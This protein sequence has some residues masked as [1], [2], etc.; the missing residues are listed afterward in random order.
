MSVIVG[1]FQGKKLDAREKIVIEVSVN[2]ALSR[3]LINLDLDEISEGA[4][5]NKTK[6]STVFV[7]LEMADLVFHPCQRRYFLS[8]NLV[9][10]MHSQRAIDQELYEKWRREIKLEEVFNKFK[11]SRRAF[12]WRRMG[13]SIDNKD[14]IVAKAIIEKNLYFFGREGA[15]EKLGF[16]TGVMG[17]A[18]FTLTDAGLFVISTKDRYSWSKELI[19]ELLNSGLLDAESGNKA[20][21]RLKLET[22]LSQLKYINQKRDSKS[23]INSDREMIIH[24][25]GE[26][27]MV[28]SREDII[29]VLIS[30]G[31]MSRED[32]VNRSQNSIAYLVD[33]EALWRSAKDRYLFH[34]TL[35]NQLRK[36]ELISEEFYNEWF[37]YF[38]REK[39]YEELE[40]KL[41]VILEKE[42]RIIL[43][44]LVGR[45]LEEFTFND[46]EDRLPYSSDAAIK[47]LQF[48]TKVGLF[49][50]KEEVYCLK[51][52]ESQF[53]KI[54]SDIGNAR[55]KKE[56]LENILLKILASKE[57]PMDAYSCLR[58]T[59]RGIEERFV[60][61]L[62]QHFIDDRLYT[63][64]GEAVNEKINSWVEDWL[65]IQGWTKEA[66]IECIGKGLFAKKYRESRL[67]TGNLV[68][69]D[70]EASEYVK[71]CE[72]I[73]GLAKGLER[74]KRDE[75]IQNEN[76]VKNQTKTESR[77]RKILMEALRTLHTKMINAQNEG[78]EK[79]V[80]HFAEMII[81]KE[82]QAG[83]TIFTEEA[84]SY[85]QLIK[86]NKP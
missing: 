73:L 10:K 54:V 61:M 42:H 81:F 17:Q 12:P 49:F 59:R 58:L 63:F 25:L 32:A 5:L 72:T 8:A 82:S 83:V 67:K 15:I 45:G 86:K 60:K 41:S 26:K 62:A 34:Q 16:G 6:L 21:R 79:M 43:D 50:K 24:L 4:N 46:I 57:N 39:S 77:D 22:A 76:Q 71:R 7:G 33:A 84:E 19:T 1:L 23:L 14:R 74:V 53:F 52:K 70:A 69:F 78:N 2:Q 55:E 38:S 9:E 66:A 18:L 29:N 65:Q 13:R 44:I 37:R 27:A 40:K 80:I 75:Q 3:G 85:L 31:G 30:K 11:Y 35:I 68:K 36:K 28:F 48:L 64:T 20:L 56:L 47:H 51:D